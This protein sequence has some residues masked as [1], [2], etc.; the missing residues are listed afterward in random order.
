MN[1][2]L[3]K[4]FKKNAILIMPFIL[5]LAMV[6]F[7]L[8]VLIPTIISIS[9]LRTQQK[10]KEE[11]L[12]QLRK[13]RTLLDSLD[14]DEI[15][16]NVADV[17]I[18]LPSD[19]NVA[20]VFT[21]LEN[22]SAKIG[23]GVDAIDTKPGVLSGEAQEAVP[24][25][26]EAKKNHGAFWIPVEITMRSSTEQ[27]RQFLQEIQKSRR[28]IDIE[29]IDLTYFDDN[30]DYVS[31]Q[32]LFQVYYLPAITQIGSLESSIVAFTDEDLQVLSL[33]KTYPDYSSV[34]IN[35]EIDLIS[36]EEVGK[37]NLFN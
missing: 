9:D 14:F 28:I 32:F 16:N 2:K 27:F 12:A 30:Q 36:E 19:K 13:K 29:N 25:I 7:T 6:Y 15:K 3:K 31:A 4:F 33:L 17:E 34:R 21:T 22:L 5:G 37:S 1:L 18:A 26:E 20:S 35:T 23:V 11:Q 10:Q 8:Q 24:E